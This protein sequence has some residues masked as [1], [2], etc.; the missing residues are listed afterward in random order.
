M[1]MYPLSPVI[2]VGAVVWMG[3]AV[4]LVRRA[5]PPRQGCWTL[6]GGKQRLGET[7]FEAVAR[8]IAEETAINIR[9][10]DIAAVVDLIDHDDDTIRYHYTVI[11]V[12]AEWAGG[13]A[14]AGDDAAEVAW[15]LPDQYGDYQLT[16]AV[17]QVIDAA[18][19]KRHR[20][21]RGLPAS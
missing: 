6:P 13:E 21:G 11:D 4:L 14:V 1:S 8:E 3:D 16:D 7:V 19:E 20:L 5:N 12:V 10:L 2:G 17:L 15:A 18:S 9:I